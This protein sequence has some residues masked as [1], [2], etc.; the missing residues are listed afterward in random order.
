MKRTMIIAVALG[1]ATFG[2]SR[3]R[4]TGN[5]VSQTRT[6]SGGVTTDNAAK[7]DNTSADNTR[8]NEIDRSGASVTPFDQSNDQAD[9]DM[10]QAIRKSVIADDTLSINAK[11][12]KI[13]TQGGKVTLRGPVQNVREHDAI[14]QKAQQLAGI[15][16]IDDQLEI[17]NP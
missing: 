16:K 7:G 5:E 11:N 6:T 9:L 3:D 4:P 2:C 14:M 10:T 1:L 8:R 13:I 12:V 17:K 15:G